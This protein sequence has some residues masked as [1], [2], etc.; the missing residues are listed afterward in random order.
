MKRILFLFLCLLPILMTEAQT[1]EEYLRQRQQAYREYI[2]K[3]NQEFIQFLKER[4]EEYAAQSPVARPKKPEPVNPVRYDNSQKPDKPVEIAIGEA[5]SDSSEPVAEKDEP[6][7]PLQPTVK[8]DVPTITIPDRPAAK[9]TP[10]GGS[11][12]QTAPKREPKK[13][14]SEKPISQKPVVT[15]PAK[16]IETTPTK[17]VV[18]TPTKPADKTPQTT[19]PEPL[20]T[21][22]APV[23]FYGNKA[24][25]ASA[26]KNCITLRGTSEE[27][28]ASAWETLCRKDYKTLVNDCDRLRKAYG[29]NDW[30]YLLLTGHVAASLCSGHNEQTLLQMFLLSQSGYKAKVARM[31]S[32]LILLVATDGILYGQ[33]YFTINGERY[34]MTARGKSGSVYTYN[35]DFANASRQVSMHITSKQLMEGNV[36]QTAHQSTAYPAAKVVAQVNEGLIAFY[37][38]YPQCEFPVYASAPVSS[39][40]E[41][42]I[43]PSLE[44]A[45]AGKSEKEAANILLN[46]V[47]TGFKYQ[48]DDEQFGYEKPFFVDELFYYP[49][50]DCEDRSVLFS[51]LVRKLMGL[52]VVLLD[53]PNHIA[54]AV[55]FREAIEGDYVSL[56]GKKYLICD[57]TYINAPIGQ[58]MPQ[59]RN[60]KAKLIRNN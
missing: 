24:Y 34:Y 5:D 25:V 44:A 28:I 47:Q 27:N 2:D 35:K 56:N 42:T 40:V 58:A 60:V 43:L 55:C 49:A 38:D 17:P 54:T 9:R 13:P 15:T 6:K 18:T 12:G 14:E 30:G 7:A 21:Q 41:N 20:R 22:G 52:D 33:T 11:R 4:W 26:M 45:I 10:Q 59:F 31:N 3:Q 53:Y 32:D 39:E 50:C 8:D 51:Y 19:A 16:P 37:K 36:K 57:P 29:L 23:S 48:T 1:Y 46:F